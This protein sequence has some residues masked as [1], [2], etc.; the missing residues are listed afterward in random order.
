MYQIGPRRLYGVNQ[1][2]LLRFFS[3]LFVG[4]FCQRSSSKVYSRQRPKQ[5]PVAEKWTSGFGISSPHP[6]V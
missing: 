1:A 2:I 6:P 4:P 3:T 5:W